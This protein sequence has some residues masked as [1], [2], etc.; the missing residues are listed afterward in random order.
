MVLK[1]EIDIELWET[2]VKN[3]QNENYKGA[4]VD[5]IFFLTDTI[6]NKTGL[7]GDGSS[8]IGQAFGGENPRIKLNNLQ[9]DSEK[10]VQRGIQEILRGI[11][12]GIRNPRSHDA[13]IDEKETADA[14]IVFINYLLGMLDKSKLSFEEDEYVKRIFD[15]YYVKSKEYSN[16]LVQ[17][18]PKRQR[19]NIAISVILKREKGDIYALAYFLE[20]LMQKLDEEEVSR[21]CKVVSDE[22]RITTEH[23]DIRYILNVIPGKYWSNIDVAVRMRIENLL[24]EDFCEGSYDKK[25]DSCGKHGALCTWITSEHLQLFNRLD[26]W[27]RQALSMYKSSNENVKA[28]IE[29]YFL[30]KICSANRENIE[31]SLKNYFKEGLNKNDE[32]IKD[33]LRVELEWDNEHPWWTVFEK[34]LKEH[35]DIKKQDIPF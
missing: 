30:D 16:L 3:Y 27:T 1:N 25:K 12:T 33:I 8:L 35:P 18:I 7:E 14:I 15:P 34:E 11:Y 10:D 21:V 17:E 9:T 29:E 5:S 31:L 23:K 32:E 28:Y 6:R 19:A 20:A 26:M 2:I 4:I 13:L 24:F 22:L